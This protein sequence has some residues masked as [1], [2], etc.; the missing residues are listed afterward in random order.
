MEQLID[1]AARRMQAGQHMSRADFLRGVAVAGAGIALGSGLVGC[2]GSTTTGTASTGTGPRRGGKLTVAYIGGGSSETLNP[3]APVADIDDARTLSL[4]E[5]LFQLSPELTL[6]YVLA[7]S[8]ESNPS[9]SVWTIRLRPGV[10]FH[11]GS[12]L[13]ADDVIYTFQRIADPKNAANQQALTSQLIDV[14]GLRKLDRLTE[15]ILGGR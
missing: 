7:E 4:Y 12:P 8:A 15:L 6:K 2:G 10:T 11:D 3:N 14:P 13:T 9:A 5:G 1:P